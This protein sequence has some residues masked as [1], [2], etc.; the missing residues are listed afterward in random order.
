[1]TKRREE[2]ISHSKMQLGR[3]SSFQEVLK[4]KKKKKSET[5]VCQNCHLTKVATFIDTQDNRII[6]LVRL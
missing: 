5:E 2:D 3:H 6:A 1:M 4:K